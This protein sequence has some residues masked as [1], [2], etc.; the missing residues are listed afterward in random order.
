LLAYAEDLGDLDDWKELPPRHSPQYPWRRQ[1]RQGGIATCRPRLPPVYVELGAA[2]GIL[3][4]LA[5]DSSRRP[6]ARHLKGRVSKVGHHDFG[7]DDE[8]EEDED[9]HEQ[10]HQWDRPAPI[11][12]RGF[13]RPRRFNF[14]GSHLDRGAQP[15]QR[16]PR[17]LRRCIAS[18]FEDQDGRRPDQLQG[19][20]PCSIGELGD[21]PDSAPLL[22]PEESKTTSYWLLNR[23]LCALSTVSIS[24]SVRILSPEPSG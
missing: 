3:A 12:R 1:S 9:H 19:L 13:L 10:D 22:G 4:I 16:Q 8:D 24:R 15:L 23:L 11:G 6:L 17:A 5:G 20:L 18:S 2:V 21:G 7:K 14:I